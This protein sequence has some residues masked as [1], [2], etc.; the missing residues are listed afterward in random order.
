MKIMKVRFEQ[1]KMFEDGIFDIDLYASD[2]VPA[3]DETVFELARP[4][5]TNNVVALAG[6]NAS[7]KTTALNL[8]GLACRA[9][10]GLPISGGGLPSSMS[11][12][13][14]LPARMKV[15]AWH[16]G[17]CFFVESTFVADEDSAPEETR[18]AFA[19]ERVGL[20]S[21]KSLKK[22]TFASWEEI[23]A[24]ANL[25][26]RRS[27]FGTAWAA[28]T[29][30][31]ISI[32]A[33]VIAEVIGRRCRI[34]VVRDGGFK[35]TKEFGGLDDV[36]KVFDLRVEH[37]EVR[38]AG[39][40]FSLR[41]EGRDPI[42]LSEQ[43]L[44][45]V[46]SSGTVRG[47]GLVQRAMTTLRSG[48]YL[49]VDEIE[50]HLN[51]QLVNVVLDLFTAEETNPKGATIV[52]STHYQQLLDHVHRKDDV[53]F[54]VRGKNG[55][56]VAVKYSD[57]VARIENKKSEVFASNYVKGTAPRYSSVRKLKSLVA[58]EVGDE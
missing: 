47:L 48:G 2:R 11:G 32:A 43:G 8:L 35:L 42:L 51:R 39:R 14:D 27:D 50:N 15:V 16:E 25:L 23:E 19:E 36:L 46:L 21:A 17:R 12:L 26:K 54:L 41:F 37:L 53:Y 31:D 28:L 40:A 55:G 38:D 44:L 58:K 49:L 18:L 1:L 29:P 57:R 34:P 4:L 56:S 10:D 33:A 52:F 6:I 20:L 45:E 7:G 13:F 30:P 5:Y 9:I 24:H 3:G 22:A